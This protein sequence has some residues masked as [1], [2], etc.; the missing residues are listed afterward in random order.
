MKLVVAHLALLIVI[1]AAQTPAPAPMPTFG[2][3][4][5][6]ADGF[7]WAENLIFDQFGNLWVTEMKRGELYRITKDA[8]N[9][10]QYKSVVWV[11]GFARILGLALDR[12]GT[13][14]YMVA[15]LTGH[16]TSIVLIDIFTAN[17]YS[18]V[19]FTD[20]I[21][22]GLVYDVAHDTLYTACEY[23]FIPYLGRILAVQNISK[24]QQTP[25]QATIFVDGLSS[26]DGLFLDRKTMKMYASEVLLGKVLVYDLLAG[27]TP[28]LTYQAPNMT[29]LDDMCITR[30]LSPNAEAIIFAA[31]FYEGNVVAFY[32]NG[33]GPS[34][35]VASGIL[36][37]T[38]VRRPPPGSPWDN[39][40]NLFITEGGPLLF[41]GTKNR[42]VWE[43]TLPR[44]WSL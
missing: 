16:T 15:E 9:P 4:T 44:E 28:I 36:N 32:E 33:T 12:L 40:R 7:N 17:N 5:L 2:N 43:L 18:V 6:I 3:L 11:Q 20:T 8:A 34:A 14:L 24:R 19:A 35:F 39:G 21:G 23:D 30:D 26:A 41:V 31:D 1:C 22:N 10:H 27:P 25:P 42:R 13:S 37:P 38:S 29:T